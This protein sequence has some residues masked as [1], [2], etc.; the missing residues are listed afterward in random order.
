M[1]ALGAELAR[2]RKDAGMSRQEDLYRASG[3]STRL[4]S[5][6]ENGKKTVS[7][8]KMRA[9]ENAL[10]LPSGATD[11][12]L[13]GTIDR[14]EPSAAASEPPRYPPGLRDDWERELWDSLPDRPES[15][16]WG[17]IFGRRTRQDETGERGSANRV[18]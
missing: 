10:R 15:F 11:D 6:I 5:D 4:I 17:I 8:S 14:L 1:E 18:S 9:I 16:R 3:V 2:I 7:V 13:A 12:Y